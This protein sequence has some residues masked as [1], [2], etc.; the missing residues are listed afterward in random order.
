L[1]S[2]GNIKKPNEA[3]KL[4]IAAIV[5]VVFGFFVGVSFPT[6]SLTKV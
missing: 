3:M 2:S 5:G 4:I 1:S 6:I